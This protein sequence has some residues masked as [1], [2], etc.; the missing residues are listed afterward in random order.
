[1][2]KWQE[3]GAKGAC[4]GDAFGLKGAINNIRNIIGVIGHSDARWTGVTP[5][6]AAAGAVS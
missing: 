2:A 1:M 4:G 5:D 3:P 6:C